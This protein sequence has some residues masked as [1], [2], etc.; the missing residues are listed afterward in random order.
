MGFGKFFTKPEGQNQIDDCK[1]LSRFL[2]S[3]QAPPPS[4]HGAR[5]THVGNNLQQCTNVFRPNYGACSSIEQPYTGL[6][7]AVKKQSNF[8]S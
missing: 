6:F 2:E 1:E 7:L 8:S 5:K 3:V 4:N